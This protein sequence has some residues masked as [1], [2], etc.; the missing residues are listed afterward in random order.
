[1]EKDGGRKETRKRRGRGEEEE[2]KESRVMRE[3]FSRHWREMRKSQGRAG[4]KGAV[5]FNR[6]LQSSSGDRL[7]PS[8][9]TCCS[10]AL[11]V[12]LHPLP[13]G[14]VARGCQ[15]ALDPPLPSPNKRDT[16]PLAESWPE[17]PVTWDAVIKTAGNRHVS[18][19]IFSSLGG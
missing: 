9:S 7:A 4:G 12:R 6:L 8:L 18:S 17:Q 15:A 10:S 19:C 14:M 16:A 5:L 3:R 2:R 13:A 11:P 1:M